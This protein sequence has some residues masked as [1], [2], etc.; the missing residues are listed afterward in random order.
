M[1]VEGFARFVGLGRKLVQATNN[2]EN[3][4]QKTLARGAHEARPFVDETMV[5]HI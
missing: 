5:A 1:E 4:M 3:K 2:Y